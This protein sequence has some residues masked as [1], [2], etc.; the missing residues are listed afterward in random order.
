VHVNPTVARLRVFARSH[1]TL[2]RTLAPLAAMA[3]PLAHFKTGRP[4]AGYRNTEALDK[5]HAA[6][7]G[8]KPHFRFP[9]EPNGYLHI[10]HAKSMKLNFGEAKA[11]GGFCYLRY[12]DTNPESEELEYIEAIEEMARWMGWV[13]DKITYSSDY[14]DTLFKFAVKLIN[15]GKAYVDHSTAEQLRKQR[16]DRANSPWR[17]RPAAENLK[18]FEHMRQGRY[19][20]GE[21][22]LRL[23]MDMQSNNPN[24]RDVIAYRI[25]YFPH[26]HI[27]DQWC[28]YPSY[29]YTHCLIDSLEQVDFSLCTLEFETRR[30][31][32]F[33]LLEAL[34]IHRPNVWEFSRL[35]VTG[36][37]LS[38]RKINKLVTGGIV[39]GFDD[40]RLL[41][42]AGLR[43]RGYTPRAI[44]NFC[45][46][47]GITRAANVI[48]IKMLE[49]SLREDLDEVCER[50]FGLLAP[51]LVKVENF[52]GEQPVD[53]PNHPRHAD[54][55]TRVVTFTPEFYIDASDFRT[56]A[57]EA[58]SKYFGLAPG[59][60]VGLKYAGNVTCSRF[61]AAADGTPTC[62]YVDVDFERAVKPKTNISWVSKQDALPVELRVYDALLN[63]DRA[64]IDPDFMQ[65]INPTSETVLRGVAE[66]CC[67]GLAM[68]GSVQFE[69]FGYFTID[70]D[71]TAG[72]LVMN[73]VISL[74]EDK[75]K[76]K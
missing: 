21:A 8:G 23:K 4:V 28:I 29:D 14:F 39:R 9:P 66:A 54:R 26:P 7:T 72:A 57:A 27:G 12:D 50:R 1:T 47:I 44:N 32:Y 31:S 51:L 33:W 52:D 55:G 10:G 42:L 68:R 13:P 22:T 34:D 37:L 74:K 20:E 17:D 65:Y 5:A 49:N 67:G 30:E 75:L 62:V 16:E 15:E 3:D 59:K 19:A 53:A 24:L 63:D 45:E 40:P 18:L 38:K 46:L 73:R 2:R 43:R 61:D 70:D 41:T 25:K 11:N 76:G 60:T 58:G 36:A 69:R 56:D 6:Y 35:N 48:D 64:A 71:S